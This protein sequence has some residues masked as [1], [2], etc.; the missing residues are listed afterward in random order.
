MSKTVTCEA[1]IRRRTPKRLSLFEVYLADETLELLSLN[2][3]E[4]KKLVAEQN[5]LGRTECNHA[6]LI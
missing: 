2:V 3:R 5:D 1:G 6:S 4:G